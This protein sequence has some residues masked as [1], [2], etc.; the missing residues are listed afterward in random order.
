MKERKVTT[1][2][3]HTIRGSDQKGKNPKDNFTNPSVHT[4]STTDPIG[5][6]VIF[7]TWNGHFKVKWFNH[8]STSR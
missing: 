8:A 7:P 3:E 1:K 4:H 2:S 6:V 5:I